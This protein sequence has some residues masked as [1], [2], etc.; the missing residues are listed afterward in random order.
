MD[1]L[2][3]E[4]A[5]QSLAR[6]LEISPSF[7]E[8]HFNLALA[9][10]ISGDYAR[11]WAEYEWR[12]R[13]PGYADYAN[14]PFGMPRWR[15]EPL[16]GRS[17]L[18]HAEQGFGDTLQF[19]RFLTR[20]AADGAQVDVFCQPP[21]APIL[22]RVEG[23]RRAVSD[24]IERPRNDYHAPIMD[25]GA[26]YLPEIAA[27]HWFGT[28]VHALPERVELWRPR[29]EPLPPPRVGLVWQGSAKNVGGYKRSMTA[30]EMA[31]RSSMAC[32]S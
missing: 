25:L 19:A 6:A 26:Y 15:G 8:A 13:A 10:L 3:I 22:S 31:Q 4:G 5:R 16:D 1:L 2:D 24:L 30:S 21:L 12:T 18:V 29:I 28:Y 11:G 20:A 23:V 32:R 9:H 27:R 14:F 7:A 17:L